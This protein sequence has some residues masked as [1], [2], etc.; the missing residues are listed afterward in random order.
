MR[1]RLALAHLPT[2][3]QRPKR[4]ADAMGV[5]LYV[6]R[7]DMTA[8]PEAGNKIRKLEYLLAAARE[9]GADCVITCGGLQSNHARATAL[10]SAGLGLRAV[11][12][13]RTADVAAGAPLEGNALLDR[14]AG[15]EVRPISPEAYRD[16]EAVMAEAAAEIRAA[17]GRP[18]VIP[19]GGSNGLGALGYVRAM[20]EIRK[21]LDL[22]LAGG[23][24]FDVIVHASSSGG[25][26]AGTALGAARYGVAGEVRAMAVSDDRATLARVALQL[27]DDARA[28]E[29]HLGAPAHLV[30]D[31][32]ARGPAYAV[33]TPE[34]RQRIVQVARLSGLVL[35]PVYTG[36]AFAGLWDLAER[37]ELAGKRVLFLHTGGLP[38]LLA[39]G[40]SF[41]DSM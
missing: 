9:E 5:D 2:P 4:L 10:L 37:G 16:R 30:V 25:T 33:A 28:L 32:S 27:M 38:G 15:A 22:G 24:P 29:P 39:Q 1:K 3:I 17:G 14:L 6:K 34:Q 35:D 13:L 26:A 21:Q 36:K 11:L 23:K 20:E 18:Y 8:G 31:D 7:D 40:A 19:E 41:A 12:Y